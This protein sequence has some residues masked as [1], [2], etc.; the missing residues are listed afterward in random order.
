MAVHAAGSP[1]NENFS[2][3][4]ELSNKAIQSA[5][6]GDQQAFVDETNIVLEALK[7]QDEK[8]S[9]IRLQR[10]SAKLKAALKAGK[11]GDL[12]EG[13]DQIEQG[14]IIMEIKK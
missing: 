9:S 2:N 4:I 12:Q 8:G 10:A 14:I 7:T 6:Q 13:I 11:A 5:K 1:M 3:L